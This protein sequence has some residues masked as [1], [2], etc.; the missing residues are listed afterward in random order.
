MSLIKRFDQYHHQIRQNIWMGYFAIFCRITLAAGFIPSGFVKINGERFT[1]L[2]NFQPLG[3]YLEALFHTGYYYPFIGVMQITAA[4]LLLI[5]RTALLG[6]FI[7]F[8][9][10][11][12]IMVLSLAVRFE[13]S[14][15][16]SPLMVMAELYL[17]VW[18]WHRIKYI[19]PFKKSTYPE[20][21]D[22]QK[23]RNKKFPFKFFILVFLFIVAL[24]STLLNMF[25]II[26]RNTIE[27][28][29]KQCEGENEETC[30]QFCECIH[31]D[32]TTQYEDCLE[33]YENAL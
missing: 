9:I 6:V 27:D 17:L 20:V 12:N 1:D 4:I 25:D 8:P 23:V 22:D 2:H 29:Q 11:L 19:F 33:A 3:Q 15:I 13:G 10:I 16:T 28:C 30:L 21:L 31:N 7:Y 32:R 14:L 24:V 26:P 5:P 18:Y